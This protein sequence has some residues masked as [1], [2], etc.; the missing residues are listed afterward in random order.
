[1]RVSPCPLPSVVASSSYTVS[2]EGYPDY[3]ANAITSDE[4][5]AAYRE[6]A[7]GDADGSGNV[8]GTST[9][10]QTTTVSSNDIASTEHEFLVLG[11]IPKVKNTITLTITDTDGN[12]TTR[13]IEQTGPKLLGEEEVRLEQAVAPD[14][15]TVTTLGNGLYAIL[16]NDP[17]SRTFMYYYDANGVIAANPVLYY[18][19]HR[20]LFDNDGI[21]WFSAS[22]KHFVGMNRLGKLVKIINLGDQYILHHDYAL[23]SDGNIVSLATDLKHSDHAVQDQVIKVDTD[24]GEVSLLVDFGDLFPDYKQST[25]HSGIDESDPTATNRWDWIHFNTIQLM[26][27]GSAL[28][29]ARETSTMIKIN[30]I[31]GTP[32]LDYMIGEPSVWDGMDAQPSFLTK[33]GDS[34]D[35][36]G[37]HSITVQYDS[38]LEDGQYY[39]YMFDNNFG[40]AMT[41]PDFD[42]T[43]IDG[44]STA[45]SSKDENS[46]SQFRKY[47]V[48]E[49]AGTYTE[50]QDFDVPYSP[51]VSSAQELSD[52][53]NLVDTG[54]QGLFGVY[55]D[56]G[57][58]KAQYEDGCSVR[59]T[60]TAST[61]TASAASTSREDWHR[62]HG[63]CQSSNGRFLSA[64]ASQ[65]HTCGES[66]PHKTPQPQPALRQTRPRARPAPVRGRWRIRAGGS[67]PCHAWRKSPACCS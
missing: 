3:T 8:G 11:L 35:T 24:S 10:S 54:M 33:V 19:S 7:A 48:D 38:S 39:I 21:M 16:G 23:D 1:M 57:N 67:Y 47:L 28:L 27:D 15:S 9:A 12:A 65:P 43:M 50:V 64:T 40:Y 60:S 34:G 45:Q 42:W 20:L 62:P 5:A 26:D 30:D 53:L 31:E 51:Y 17:T 6:A 44:I 36:G 66:D 37:Q 29:S 49:N 56:D 52:D 14:E 18:R 63:R 2:A 58:L 32:S 41:R 4:A 25:D 13:T 22:T 59:D 61:S 55:D 46:N